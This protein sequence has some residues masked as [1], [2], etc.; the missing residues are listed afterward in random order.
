[1][2]IS[3]EAIDAA[4]AR[5][6]EDGPCAVAARYRP[7]IG[8]IEIE[9]DN[10][11]TLAVPTSLIQGLAGAQAADLSKIEISPAGRGLHF[12][13]LDA[14]VFVPALFEGIYGSKA[15]MKQSASTAGSTRS[16]AKSAAAR[17]NGKKGGR[18]RKVQEEAHA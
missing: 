18:P 6:K 5:V 12:P 9:F 4:R 3:K 10:G 7:S 11:V 2:A 17:A 1:M 16:P 13:R 8:K 14:D 15:W